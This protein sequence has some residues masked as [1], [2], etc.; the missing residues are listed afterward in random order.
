MEK[1]RQL[2]AFF[3]EM[4]DNIYKSL[5]RGEYITGAKK[6][7]IEAPAHEPMV[8]VV[9]MV[10]A[11]DE[12]SRIRT[13]SGM[14]ESLLVELKLGTKPAVATV[15]VAP[16]THSTAPI[17]GRPPLPTGQ[18][19]NRELDTIDSFSLSPEEAPEKKL[20]H[21]ESDVT[22]ELAGE[23]LVDAPI[24]EI[25]GLES[26][27]AM[28]AGKKRHVRRNTGGTIYVKTTMMNPDVQ[29]TIKVC[30]CGWVG[31]E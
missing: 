7:T 2:R 20:S 13:I 21:M 9:T 29:A 17:R 30:V 16:K 25:I 10:T 5:E 11:M 15:P 14:D 4:E 23:S 8:P 26:E 12:K 3:N 1:K 18:R 24:G 28:I 6:L 31:C 22:A 27:S 19:S